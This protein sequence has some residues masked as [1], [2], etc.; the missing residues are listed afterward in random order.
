ML[1]R[2]RRPKNICHAALPAGKITNLENGTAWLIIGAAAEYP[3]VGPEWPGQTPG[4]V[5]YATRLPLPPM[6]Y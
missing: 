3:C 6:E 2:A 5:T 1:E 4:G